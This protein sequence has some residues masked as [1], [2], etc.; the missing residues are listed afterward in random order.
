MRGRP[1]SFE[2]HFVLFVVTHDCKGVE[3]DTFKAR[4]V[5]PLKPRDFSESDFNFSNFESFAFLLASACLLSPPRAPEALV[6]VVAATTTI[7]FTQI[8]CHSYSPILLP[9]EFDRSWASLAFP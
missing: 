2:G 5:T 3:R 7:K 4:C 1:G 9:A 8:L 6:K